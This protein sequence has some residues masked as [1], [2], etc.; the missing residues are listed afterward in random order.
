V[1][2]FK[3]PKQLDSFTHVIAAH[4]QYSGHTTIGQTNDGTIVCADRVVAAEILTN[5]EIKKRVL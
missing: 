2:K 1:I 4:I 3:S 5:G